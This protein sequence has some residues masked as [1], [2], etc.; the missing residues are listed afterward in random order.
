MKATKKQIAAWKE[1]Y[2]AL[3]VEEYDEEIED[4]SYNYWLTEEAHFQSI[5]VGWCMGQGMNLAEAMD[6][7]EQMIPLNLF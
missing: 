4:Q 7:Y 6:F 5:C 3:S 1:I 2:D